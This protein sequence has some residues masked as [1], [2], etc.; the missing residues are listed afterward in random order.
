MM[1]SFG[2]T[3]GEVNYFFR[4]EKIIVKELLSLKIDFGNVNIDPTGRYCFADI[5]INNK[6]LVIGSIYAPTKDEPAFFD[7][8]FSVIA[9]F[10]HTDL[11]LAGVWNVVLNDTLEK[12][13]DPPHVN[14]NSKEKIKSYMGFFQF[15]RCFS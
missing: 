6:S 4:M 7:S 10:S 11:I 8:L 3:N 12:D 5:K 13:K 1:K 9:N 15:K 2:N 14:R